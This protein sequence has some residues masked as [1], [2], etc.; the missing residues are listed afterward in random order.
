MYSGALRQLEQMEEKSGGLLRLEYRSESPPARR[1]GPTP[2]LSRAARVSGVKK[3]KK[4][5]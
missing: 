2:F 3:K 5:K 1:C 4:S